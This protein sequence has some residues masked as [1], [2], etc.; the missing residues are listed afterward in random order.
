MMSEMSMM[1]DSNVLRMSRFY[2][3]KSYRTFVLY[4]FGDKNIRLI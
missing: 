4:D 1:T 3:L 2:L